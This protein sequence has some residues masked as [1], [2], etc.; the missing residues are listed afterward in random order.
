M[1]KTSFPSQP[2]P[3]SQKHKMELIFKF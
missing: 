2:I 1:M 3:K